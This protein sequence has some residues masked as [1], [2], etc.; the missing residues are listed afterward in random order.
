MAV[1]RVQITDM[2]GPGVIEFLM[3]WGA[4]FV[5]AAAAIGTV[6]AVIVALRV[7]QRSEDLRSADYEE[8]GTIV[9]G[10][11]IPETL[12]ML[13]V[14]VTC[15]AQ[16][17]AVLIGNE[18]LRELTTPP[19]FGQP[20]QAD[21][22]KLALE[23]NAKLLKALERTQSLIQMT[24]AKEAF[25]HLHFMPDGRGRR[26]A[27]ALGQIESLRLNVGWVLR[28]HSSSDGALPMIVDMTEAEIGA[29]ASHLLFV[30]PEANF[31]TMKFALSDAL[32][33]AERAGIDIPDHHKVRPKA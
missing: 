14:L 9:S 23:E 4:L 11:V 13:A 12:T 15:S 1:T 5:Q 10:V 29:I 22:L 19:H 7:A 17:R 27:A 25:E 26:V 20:G 31:Q 8:R 16:V 2:P 30:V 21:Q 32:A 3:Q 18:L 6:W 24:A 33:S 28:Q